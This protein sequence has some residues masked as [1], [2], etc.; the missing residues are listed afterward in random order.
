MR[1][2]DLNHWKRASHFRFYSNFAN[3]QYSITAN[4]NI[5]HLY[6]YCKTSGLKLYPAY[7]FAAQKVVHQIEEF[8]Q[9]IVNGKV[10]VFSEVHAA[11]TV[12]LEDETFRFSVIPFSSAYNAF[13]KSYEEQTKIAQ[14]KRDLNPDYDGKDLIYYTAIPWISFTSLTNPNF[15]VQETVP[16][17]A[18]GKIVKQGSDFFIPVAVEVHHALVDGLHIGKF[19]EQL[20]DSFRSPQ[21]W[22]Q[23]P[24]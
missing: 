4:C 13:Y 9:R 15:D 19:F 21:K 5:T 24:V 10:V 7:L 2:I 8:R 23:M 12:P 6:N 22:M 11:P 14:G 16:R 1:E 17:I 18:F 3:P 20:E